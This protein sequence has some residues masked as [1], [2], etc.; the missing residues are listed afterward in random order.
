MKD[1]LVVGDSISAAREADTGLDRGWPEIMGIPADMRQAVSGSTAAEWAMDRNGMLTKARNTQA[2]ILIM[3]IMA[4]DIMRAAS[5]GRVT[6]M[7]IA[8]AIYD[9]SQVLRALY[10]PLTIV[11]LYADPFCGANAQAA[12]VVP[13]LNQG[14]RIACFGRD[15]VF[16]ELGEILGPEHSYGTDIHPTRA[17]HAVIAA[18]LIDVIK[19]HGGAE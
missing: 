8:A 3:S 10:R 9:M 12:A 17:G 19:T 16:V 7:E 13:R 18:H 11:L 5:D 4:N 2:D 15:V 6:G 1:I 14:C